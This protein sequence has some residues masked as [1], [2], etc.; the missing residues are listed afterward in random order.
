M[1]IGEIIFLGIIMIII[2][3]IMLI[4]SLVSKLRNKKSFKTAVIGCVLVLTGI[5]FI[6]PMFLF[7]VTPGIRVTEAIIDET[8]KYINITDEQLQSYPH[9][10]KAIESLGLSIDVPSKEYNAI[11]D[12][13]DDIVST[14]FRYQNKFYG[15]GFRT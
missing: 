13:F 5:T 11:L 8:D 2:A 6:I 7:N 12:L 4:Y 14:Y 3:A 9:L 1:G 15:I 10:K